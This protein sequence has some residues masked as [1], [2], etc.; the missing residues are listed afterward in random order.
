MYS[1]KRN[2]YYVFGILK[3]INFLLGKVKV[4]Q[5]VVSQAVQRT[6]KGLTCLNNQLFIANRYIILSF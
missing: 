2:T 6:G 5:K 3:R 4:L 1:E